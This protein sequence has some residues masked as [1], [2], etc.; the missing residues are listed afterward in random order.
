MEKY[1]MITEFEMARLVAVSR[2]V[3]G[4]VPKAH[5]THEPHTAS[6][7]AGANLFFPEKGSS[8]RDDQADTGK[9]RAR[10]IN[11]CRRIHWETGWDPGLPSNCF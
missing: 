6:M 2:L 1:G 3:M 4:R 8:P 11:E 9:G 10:D 7:T 5:C